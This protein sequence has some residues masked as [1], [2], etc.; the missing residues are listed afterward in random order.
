MATAEPP[1]K[2]ARGDDG[3]LDVIATLLKQIEQKD[4]MIQNYESIIRSNERIQAA[5]KEE[6]LHKRISELERSGAQAP[7]HAALPL[8]DPSV[9]DKWR[10]F[11][12][13]DLKVMCKPDCRDRFFS[14]LLITIEKYRKF[15][16][17]KSAVGIQEKIPT[18]PAYIDVKDQ[19]ISW[20]KEE[21]IRKG[22]YIEIYEK[23]IRSLKDVNAAKDTEMRS[24]I[25]SKD[26]ALHHTISTKDT[27][28]RHTEE[29][30][31]K[32]KVEYARREAVMLAKIREL[33]RQQPAALIT[34]N[35]RLKAELAN[36]KSPQRPSPLESAFHARAK[37]IFDARDNYA[38]ITGNKE[39]AAVEAMVKLS[40]TAVVD[41]KA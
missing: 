20:L 25:S 5:N 28:I 13:E 38:S 21:T 35:K 24:M 1:A 9:R 8:T 10:A 18:S 37:V 23:E 12:E 3:P 39:K 31:E 22:A 34:E 19:Q 29:L 16:C 30:L 41:D 2:R 33:E 11:F 14:S 15:C 7:N 27:T 32:S 40:D 17:Q 26:Y 6:L 36:I 4:K